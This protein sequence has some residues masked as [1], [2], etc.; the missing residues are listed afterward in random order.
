MRVFQKLLELVLGRAPALEVDRAVTRALDS[1]EPKLKFAGGYPRRYRLAIRQAL[2]YAAELASQ[3]PGPLAAEPDRFVSN[4]TLRAFFATPDHIQEALA[5]SRA[6]HDFQRK[7]DVAG[8][9]FY[10][11]LGMRRTEKNVLGMEIQDGMLRRDVAQTVITFADHT[12]T[13]AAQNETEAREKL[14]WSFFDSLM[15][16]VKAERETWRNE[17]FELERSLAALQPGRGAAP[18]MGNSTA[19]VEMTALSNQIRSLVQLQKFDRAP[20]QFSRIVDDPK[21]YLRLETKRYHFDAMGVVRP[22]GFVE[23][24]NL[25]E[26]KDLIGRDRRIWTISLVRFTYPEQAD[27]S[28]RLEQASRW[29]AI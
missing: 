23:A 8:K 12:L 9:P 19:S 18:G 28:R 13:C 11:L 14:M 24:T 15:G 7:G 25:V 29:L 10:G 20:E 5:Q 16:R 2:K 17:Q 27:F 21:R 4:P 22:L 6:I 1:V 26:F 3:V